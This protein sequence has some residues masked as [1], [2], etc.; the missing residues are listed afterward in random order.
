MAAETITHTM[1]EGGR[2]CL[3]RW[4]EDRPRR[5]KR[6]R[7]IYVVRQDEGEDRAI[8]VSREEIIDPE[9]GKGGK[10]HF[11]YYFRGR[12]SLESGGR[13]KYIFLFFRKRG[14]G[15]ADLTYFGKPQGRGKKVRTAIPGKGGAPPSILSRREGAPPTFSPAATNGRENHKRG[16]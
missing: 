8:Y 7:F 5:E 1:S 12:G 6:I 4:G 13:R 9:G 10:R 11:Y 2:G 3:L 15:R 14:G 16:R